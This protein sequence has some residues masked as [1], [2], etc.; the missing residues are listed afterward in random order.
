MARY[1]TPLRTRTEEANKL[2]PDVRAT[3]IAALD[4]IELKANAAAN[5]KNAPK[6]KRKT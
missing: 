1:K 5:L 3:E 2:K 6:P 4:P